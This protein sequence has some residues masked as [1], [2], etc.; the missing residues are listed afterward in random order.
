MEVEH[1]KLYV[2]LNEGVGAKLSLRA[3][4]V[5]TFEDSKSFC[6]II[7]YGNLYVDE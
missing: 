2:L 3:L 4:P 6:S 7:S 1:R 5:L